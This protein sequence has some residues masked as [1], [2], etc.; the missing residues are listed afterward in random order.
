MEKPYDADLEGKNAIEVAF[1]YE[2]A[3]D[4]DENDKKVY[5]KK[6]VNAKGKT[7]LA[8]F[9]FDILK[10]SSRCCI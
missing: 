1:A 5:T 4:F 9:L 6:E 3:Y 7:L 10:R 8:T 2:F